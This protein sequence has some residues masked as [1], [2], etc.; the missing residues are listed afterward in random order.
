MSSKVIK[1]TAIPEPPP[2][3]SYDILGLTRNEVLALA[4]AI[5]RQSQIEYPRKEST[6]Y[7]KLWQAVHGDSHRAFREESERLFKNAGLFSTS[8]MQWKP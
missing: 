3:E 6:L 8:P 5:G 2:L 1:R 7:D 4:V